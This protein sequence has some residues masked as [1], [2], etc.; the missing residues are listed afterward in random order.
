MII[1]AII[2]I[3]YF[4][5]PERKFV[6]IEETKTNSSSNENEETQ[7]VDLNNEKISENDTAKDSDKKEIK[8]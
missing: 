2:G 4:S 7:K 5:K 6:P 1:G 3:I 8:I